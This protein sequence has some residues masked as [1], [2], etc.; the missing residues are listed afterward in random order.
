MAPYITPAQIALLYGAFLGVVVITKARAA[1][2]AP[3][4]K[5]PAPTSG[6]SAAATTA[7][8]ASAAGAADAPSAPTA[9]DAG[10]LAAP[11]P[12]AAPAPGR[13][14][15]SPEDARGKKVAVRCAV[16]SAVLGCIALAIVAV[17][18][19]E[20]QWGGLMDVLDRA[21]GLFP[22]EVAL[23]RRLLL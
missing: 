14:Q 23:V 3:P 20:Q 1:T 19:H 7:A 15:W 12:A 2:A 11:A 9:A 22:K 17:A 13:V 18:W 6:A 8:A 10:A 5:A 21:A 16:D 4:P